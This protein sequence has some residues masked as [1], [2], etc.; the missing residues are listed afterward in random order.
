MNAFGFFVSAQFAEE[1]LPRT[2]RR[3]S[4][5]CAFDMLAALPNLDGRASALGPEYAARCI[6]K[7]AAHVLRLTSGVTVRQWILRSETQKN[8]YCCALQSV[9]LLAHYGELEPGSQE[10]AAFAAKSRNHRPESALSELHALLVFGDV[11]WGVP[12]WKAPAHPLLALVGDAEK[13]G[14]R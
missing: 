11:A 10:E 8:P 2:T 6:V 13:K 14:M 1:E 12:A 4:L 3:E 9:A 7:I 5:L